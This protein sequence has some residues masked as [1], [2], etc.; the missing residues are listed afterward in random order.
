MREYGVDR[1]SSLFNVQQP[2][3]IDSQ[4]LVYP[5]NYQE[6]YGLE[7]NQLEQKWLISILE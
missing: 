6:V 2:E 4:R 7:L 5:P 1:L 3:I